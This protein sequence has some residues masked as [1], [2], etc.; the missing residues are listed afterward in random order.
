MR[1]TGP[2]RYGGLMGTLRASLLLQPC[3]LL[4]KRRPHSRRGPR[5]ESLERGMSNRAIATALA[6]SPGLWRI[7]FPSC[8][9]KPAA[10]PHQLL[11][12]ALAER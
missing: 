6:L 5:P 10:E 11:L 8:W 4:P 2:D 1:A 12:W 3:P 9:R 7:M